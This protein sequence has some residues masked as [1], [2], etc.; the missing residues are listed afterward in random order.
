MILDPDHRV[1]LP[2]FGLVGEGYAER[3]SGALQTYQSIGT[4]K[5]VYDT[6]C[7]FD[8]VLG[9]N[10]DLFANRQESRSLFSRNLQNPVPSSRRDPK[11]KQYLLCG[12]LTASY[13]TDTRHPR[14]SDTPPGCY[15][16]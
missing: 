7:Q 2:I 6:F 13:K 14:S 3:S 10:V 5:G 11:Q 8:R 9:Y 12:L 15:Q 4:Q 16:R 1:V